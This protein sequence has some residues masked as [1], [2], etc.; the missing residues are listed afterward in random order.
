MWLVLIQNKGT[1][2]YSVIEQKRCFYIGRRRQS[3][4]MESPRRIQNGT[5]ESKFLSNRLIEL[6]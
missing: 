4:P 1:V 2:H 3:F 6:A 5:I